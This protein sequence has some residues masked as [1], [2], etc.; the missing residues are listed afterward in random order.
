MTFT[1]IQQKGSNFPFASLSDHGAQP[2]K[3]VALE[4][5][6]FSENREILDSGDDSDD[7]DDLPSVSAILARSR[8]LQPQTPVIDLTCDSDDD[9]LPSVSAIV[10]RSRRLQPQTPVIDLT[11]D[12]NDDDTEVS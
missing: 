10:A 4:G 9:D 3:L 2:S 5:V 1:C 8:R 11:C 12:S 7:D 6:R